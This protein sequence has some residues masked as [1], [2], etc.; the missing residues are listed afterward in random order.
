MSE[1]Q[2]RKHNPSGAIHRRERVRV[3]KRQVSTKNTNICLPWVLVLFFVLL[4][5]QQV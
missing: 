4:L 3:D 2:R 5:E 1:S